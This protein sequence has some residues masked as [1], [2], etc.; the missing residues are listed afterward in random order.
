MSTIVPRT[1]VNK[2]ISLILESFYAQ[3]QVRIPNTN[4]YF[5]FVTPRDGTV[6]GVS[7]QTLLPDRFLK[8][9]VYI[10]GFTAFGDF[11]NYRIEQII[12]TNN[13]LD[14]YRY[15]NISRLPKTL[16]PVMYAASREPSAVPDYERD[17]VLNPKADSDVGT[18]PL[19]PEGGKLR[20]LTSQPYEI[21]GND[22][23]ATEPESIRA[24]T[25]NLLTSQLYP[26]AGNELF[27]SN[28]VAPFM[29]KIKPPQ[30]YD[31]FQMSGYLS[32]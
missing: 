29:K 10:E 23:V 31:Q 12:N 4:L 25:I 9:H 1:E 17:S 6:L 5:D 27:V 32:V 19:T 3:L 24:G 20:Y 15:V 13:G 2:L 14:D 11:G 28:P 21:D 7:V 26:V 30:W 18:I 22:K 8:I 16:F